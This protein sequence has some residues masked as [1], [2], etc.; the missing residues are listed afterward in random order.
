MRNAVGAIKVI[1]PICVLD[2]YVHESC[3]RSGIGKQLFSMMLKTAHAEPHK[4]AYDRPSPKLMGFLRKYYKLTKFVP[5]QNN[6]VVFNKYFTTSS[7]LNI[8]DTGRTGSVSSRPLT[9][10]DRH[11]RPI[12]SNSF[13]PAD[14]DDNFGASRQL[15][16]HGAD[17]SRH[18]AQPST[19][20][21]IKEGDDRAVPTDNGASRRPPRHDADRSRHHTQA[22]GS[23][24]GNE[25]G[26]FTNRAFSPIRGRPHSQSLAAGMSSMA[27]VREAA[28]KSLE[29]SR[30]GRRDSSPKRQDR[31]RRSRCRDTSRL[32]SAASSILAVGG[33]TRNLPPIATA[34]AS[35]G[36][37][38]I[39]RGRRS[40]GMRTR[41][42]S[43][44]F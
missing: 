35:L 40:L 5:Q 43:I 9:A 15:P 32:S 21:R 6:Y 30:K 42:Q 41:Y 26:T 37:T 25:G 36:G 14:N 13:V 16:R 2:F 17:R 31:L 11:G 24:R 22:A 4:L 18:R 44:L 27:A 28:R 38:R 8:L 20:P 3:Q 7:S 34:P 12:H 1:K 19:K 29:T 39:G 10:R 23:P 33:R